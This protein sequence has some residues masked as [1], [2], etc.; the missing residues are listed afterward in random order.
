M[1]R[2]K[3]R[4]RWLDDA[5]QVIGRQAAT[6]LL[7]QQDQTEAISELAKQIARLADANWRQAEATILLARATAGEFDEQ[8]S[9]PEP[10]TKGHGMGMG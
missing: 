2:E 7:I 5:S 3:D 9:V 6:T 10:I 1:S 8:E 4:Q